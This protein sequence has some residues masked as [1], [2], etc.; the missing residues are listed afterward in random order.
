[1]ETR[2][3][4]NAPKVRRGNHDQQVARKEHA[5]GCQRGSKRSAN[6][7]TDKGH[8]DYQAPG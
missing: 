7:V 4:G 8:G 1:L 3:V 2:I 6:Q 5:Q